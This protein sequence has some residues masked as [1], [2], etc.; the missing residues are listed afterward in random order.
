VLLELLNELKL[1]TKFAILKLSVGKQK[2]SF[3]ENT[4]GTCVTHSAYWWWMFPSSRQ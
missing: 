1:A 3:I 2:A 4:D